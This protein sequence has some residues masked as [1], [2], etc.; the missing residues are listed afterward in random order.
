MK[1]KYMS[2]DE[3]IKED[4]WLKSLM[5]DLGFYYEKIV[6]FC[7]SLSVIFGQRS[8]VTW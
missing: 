4:I 7:N 8:C 3:T 1:P 2:L 5:V 6:I